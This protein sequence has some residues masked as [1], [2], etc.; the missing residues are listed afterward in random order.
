[1]S[2]SNVF[3]ALS[4]LGWRVLRI[5]GLVLFGVGAF[6]VGVWYGAEQLP[7]PVR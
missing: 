3:A 7:I 4:Q 1:M 2:G 5:A 6:L